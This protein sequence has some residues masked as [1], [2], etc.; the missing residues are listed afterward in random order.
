[1]IIRR[2]HTANFTTI[3]NRLFDDERLAADEL[4]ILAYLRS[5]PHD[6]EVRR[7]VLMK[8]FRIG[9]DALKRIVA[10]WMRC[11]WCGAQKTK[12]PDGTFCIIY[13]I[14]DEPGPELSD[15][16][17]RRALSPESGEVASEHVVRN[18][19]PCVYASLQDELCGQPPTCQPALGQPALADRPLDNI[20]L[21]NKELTKK[22][23]TNQ[24]ERESEADR[25]K[26]A[27]NLVEFRKRYPTVPSDDQVR[28]DNAWFALNLAEGEAAIAR[29]PDFLA[30]QKKD[31]RTK[32]PAS[33]TYLAQK[34][35]TLLD[36]A[37]DRVKPSFTSFPSTS[38]EAAAIRNLYAIGR[39]AAPFENNG[40]LIYPKPVTPQ[41]LAFASAGSA[42]SWEFVELGKAIASWSAFLDAHIFGVRSP[43]VVTRGDRRGIF[44]P[45]L[46]PPSV[47]GKVYPIHGD[48]GLGPDDLMTDADYENFDR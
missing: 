31:G 11:G 7:P 17:I 12:R 36:A 9:R 41:L 26:H 40:R 37:P 18:S 19:D 27:A 4:G 28:L 8:R 23:S 44:V 10:N 13:E 33:F 39:A 16:E 25:A 14:R 42:S 43:F 47:E 45:W 22:D 20:D 48:T 5:K 3:G 38:P 24:I 35:W 2:R 32:H 21:Q 34:R 46:F 30:K 1:M 15:D 29:I 6:W